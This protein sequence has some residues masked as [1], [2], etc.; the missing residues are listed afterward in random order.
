MGKALGAKVRSE[1]GILG[2]NGTI[3]TG[4]VRLLEGLHNAIYRI[5]SFPVD[6]SLQTKP[7]YPLNSTLCNLSRGM[8][9]RTTRA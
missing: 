3:E 9:I 8:A 7:R 4:L 6:K 1:L 5:N 2:G